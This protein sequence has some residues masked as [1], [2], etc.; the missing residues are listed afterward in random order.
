M[1][2]L[3]AIEGEEV[4]LLFTNN[5]AGMLAIDTDNQNNLYLLMPVQG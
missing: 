5:T 3:E 1:D 4:K 2:S